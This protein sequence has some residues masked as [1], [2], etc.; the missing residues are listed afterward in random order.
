VTDE[1]VMGQV[2][3]PTKTVCPT[4]LRTVDAV[5]AGPGDAV[6]LQAECPEHASW[7]TAVWSGSPDFDAWC[8]RG[9]TAP[10]T[11]T[12]TALFEVTQRCDLGCP[13]CF[14]EAAPAF[15]P[16]RSDPPLAMLSDQFHRLFQEE[17]AVNIQLSGGE[18]TMRD[19]LPQIVEAASKAGFTFVQLNTN[20]I[21]LAREEGYAERLRAAGL[22]SVF[23]QFDGISDGPYEALRARPLLDLKLRTLQRC[24]EA[25][26]AVV[27]VPTLAAGVNDHEVGGLVRLAASW[28]GVVRGLHFQPISYFGRYQPGE[29][30]RLTLPEVLR[31]LEAQTGGALRA[32]DFAPSCCEHVRCSFRARYW[33]REEGRLEL[34]RS[35]TPSCCGGAASEP[36]RRAVAATARQWASARGGSVPTRDAGAAGGPAVRPDAA[37]GLTAFLEEAGRMLTVSGMLF[38]D[39]WNLDW[40]RVD[41]CCVKVVTPERGLVSFCLWNLTS[42]SGARYYPR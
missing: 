34:V 9:N 18:P 11:Q 35:A 36:A 41:R 5:L 33:V 39:A 23:L 19:D 29:R 10:A 22:A 24:A 2:S 40:E 28:A 12:C 37:D 3:Q 4:C 1:G 14:A 16:G 7:C 38:Q 31:E 17:G 27:L 6:E 26:L 25:G 42:A 13:V 20:G 21:R 30:R 8:E 32:S 15:G